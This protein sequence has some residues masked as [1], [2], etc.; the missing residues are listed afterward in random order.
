MTATVALLSDFIDGTSLALMEDTDAADL[1]AFMTASQ[2]RL[3]ADVQNKR[4]SRGLTCKRRGPGTLYFC[5]TDDAVQAL[6]RYLAAETGSN[7]EQYWLDQMKEAGVDI[8]P[9]VG[10]P[11]E[12]RSLLEEPSSLRNPPR[13]FKA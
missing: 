3:W 6:E 13:G 1:N 10:H 4:R 9:H 8:A 2:G 5:R 7:Q 12:R 11:S